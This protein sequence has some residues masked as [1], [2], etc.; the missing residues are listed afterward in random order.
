M[1]TIGKA[2]ILSKVNSSTIRYYEEEGIIPKIE[3]NKYGHR[4]LNDDDITWIS[5]VSCLRNT[6]MSLEDIKAIVKLTQ[7]G[8]PGL[9]DKLQIFENHRISISEQINELTSFAN[10]L[11][12]KIKKIKSMM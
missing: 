2:A 10:E 12:K 4:I 7:L 11:D 5:L 1:Y 3:R 9:D 6:G 8:K